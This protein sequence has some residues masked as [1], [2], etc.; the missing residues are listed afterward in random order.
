M[1]LFPLTWPD[2]TKH[3]E[4][5]ARAEAVPGQGRGTERCT[6]T[7]LPGAASESAAGGGPWADRSHARVLRG[8]AAGTPAA[9]G[10]AA[11]RAEVWLC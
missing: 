4:L 5:M 11:E 2:H 1:A 7:H 8:S 10:R 6:G 9:P 3:A